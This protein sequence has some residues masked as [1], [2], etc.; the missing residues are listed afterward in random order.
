MKKTLFG[1]MVCALLVIIS[2]SACASNRFPVGVFSNIA[3]DEYV[4]ELKGDNTWTSY[5]YGEMIESGTYS[6][7]DN[8]FT[9]WMNVVDDAAD[10]S[11]FVYEW[12]YEDDILTLKL[13]SE[14]SYPEQ[15]RIFDAKAFAINQ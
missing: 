8:E 7:Q 1:M 10:A 15:F 13:C 14:N 3:L 9:L 4:L 6:V 12:S 2:L 5:V 11:S